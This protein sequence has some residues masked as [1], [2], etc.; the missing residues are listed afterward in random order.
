[1]FEPPC[2]TGHTICSGGLN[3]DANMVVQQ[4]LQR[5]LNRAMKTHHGSAWLLSSLRTSEVCY[6]LN[7]RFSWPAALMFLKSEI[8]RAQVS[9]SSEAARWRPLVNR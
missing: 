7:S 2:N 9:N 8:V 5:M 4:I 1:M 6:R 3:S